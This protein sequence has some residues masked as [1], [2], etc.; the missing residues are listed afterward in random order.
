MYDEVDLACECAEDFCGDESIPL[1][2]FLL[3]GWLLFT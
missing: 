1:W 2:K 3:L